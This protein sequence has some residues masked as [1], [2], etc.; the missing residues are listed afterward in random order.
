MYEE[1]EE[2]RNEWTEWLFGKDRHSINKQIGMILWD[3][4]IQHHRRGEAFG[5]GC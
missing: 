2:K 5:L 1:F 3:T 4:A